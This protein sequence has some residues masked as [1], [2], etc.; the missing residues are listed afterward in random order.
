MVTLTISDVPGDDPSIIASGPAGADASTCAD[1]LAILDRY[2]AHH[3]ASPCARSAG[4]G[5][6]WKPPNPAMPCLQAMRSTCIATRGSRSKPQ[7]K[8][9]A[10]QAGLPHILSDEIEG[11]SREVGKVH[12]ALA[13]AVAQRGAPFERPCVLLSGGETTVTV[14]PRPKGAPKGRGGR[15]GEFCMGLAQALQGR[16]GVWPWRPTP[17]ASTA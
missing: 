7:P 9:P 12:A 1:A 4:G 14:R 15:A 3:R 16:S 2:G 17:M 8:P 10:P 6:A 13:R 5:R 11:E